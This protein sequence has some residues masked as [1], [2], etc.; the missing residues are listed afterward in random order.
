MLC[1]GKYV[2]IR[3]VHTVVILPQTLYKQIDAVFVKIIQNISICYKKYWRFFAVG[4]V[5]AD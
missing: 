2:L 5:H 1:P 4:T 3:V